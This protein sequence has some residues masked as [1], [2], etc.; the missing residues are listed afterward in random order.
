MEMSIN[1][2]K[3][4]H[5]SKDDDFLLDN[6]NNKPQFIEKLYTKIQFTI[7]FSY[8]FYVGKLH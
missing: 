5:K 3:E 4:I 1:W 2:K 6:K 7:L 8:I